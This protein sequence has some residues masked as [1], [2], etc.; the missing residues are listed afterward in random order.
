MIVSLSATF[1]NRWNSGGFDFQ[2]VK[3]DAFEF[4][5]TLVPYLSNTFEE[6]KEQGNFIPNVCNEDFIYVA[7]KSIS[8][9]LFS[10]RLEGYT[11]A[12]LNPLYKKI[13]SN[14]FIFLLR[15]R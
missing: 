9:S 4:D 11:H 10:K 2:D 14:S 6:Y 7:S 3:V 5:Q 1:L 13:N 8:G 15:Q 12:I